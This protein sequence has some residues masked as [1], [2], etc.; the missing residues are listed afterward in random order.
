MTDS[1][2]YVSGHRHDPDTDIWHKFTGETISN[3]T[4]ASFREEEEQ[5]R[6][7]EK[8]P[9]IYPEGEFT[10]KELMALNE[11]SYN[12]ARAR[13]IEEGKCK[14]VGER[15][16]RGIPAKVYAYVA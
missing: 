14:E 8:V 6:T 15:K 2:T 1:C 3:G 4:E 16:A 11:M 10:M 12:V 5:V 7:N 13:L 9:L